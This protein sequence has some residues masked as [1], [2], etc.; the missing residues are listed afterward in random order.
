MSVQ[1]QSKPEVYK[2]SDVEIREHPWVPKFL[3]P[4]VSLT[5][6]KQLLHRERWCAE[7]NSVRGVRP[8]RHNVEP[9]VTIEVG[10]RHA[11]DDSFA[12]VPGHLME[13]VSLPRVV[14]DG[15][16]LLHPANN[17]VRP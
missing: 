14:V 2:H 15:S 3:C 1:A 9:T 10:K 17:N 7:P 5:T 8:R 4:Q 16:R 13:A 12:V 6:R 11:V